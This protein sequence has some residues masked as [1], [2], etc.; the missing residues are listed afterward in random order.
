MSD[1][2]DIKPNAPISL[3]EAAGRILRGVV[4]PRFLR[5]AIRTGELKG[6]KLG[7]SIYTTPADVRAWMERRECK[8][9]SSSLYQAPRRTYTRRKPEEQET[10]QSVLEMLER[11]KREREAQR[12][13]AQ[14]RRRKEREQKA[15]PKA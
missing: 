7:R 9:S 4:T 11:P 1:T 10:W 3:E 6:Y 12:Q 13:A 15:K 5:D 2:D 8:A 14:E